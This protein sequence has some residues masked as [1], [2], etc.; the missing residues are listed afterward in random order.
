VFSL[1]SWLH[2]FL[3]IF[4]LLPHPLSPSPALYISTDPCWNWIPPL[5]LFSILLI[6][7]FVFKQV[8]VA[9]FCLTAFRTLREVTKPLVLSHLIGEHAWLMLTRSPCLL[10]IVT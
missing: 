3:V 7:G 2:F 8:S 1:D 4:H 10:C 5:P 9:W 6:K